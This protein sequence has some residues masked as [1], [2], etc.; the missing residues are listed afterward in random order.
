MKTGKKLLCALL[1][2]VLALGMLPLTAGATVTYPDMDDFNDADDVT[3]REAVAV[4]TAIRAVDGR[5]GSFWPTENVQRADAVAMVVRMM[6]GR[7]L[8]DQLP[9]GRTGFSD[10]DGVTGLGWS[11]R[12]IAYAVSQGIVTGVGGGRFA[13]RSN[14]TASQLAVMLLRVLGVDG[15]YTGSGWEINAIVD[16]TNEGIL[17]GTGNVGFSNAATREQTAQYVFNTLIKGNF[18]ERSSTWYLV[19]ATS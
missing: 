8:A 14:V 4:L 1:V 9:E 16:G 12:Y 11:T 6:L 2:L 18:V 15:N 13:P 10:V 3:L 7:D 17:S 5:A 19:S